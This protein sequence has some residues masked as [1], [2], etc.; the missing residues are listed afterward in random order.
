MSKIIM[1]TDLSLCYSSSDVKYVW[2][3]LEQ[4]I[5]IVMNQFIPKITIKQNHYPKWYTPSLKHQTNCLRSLRKKFSK[6]RTEHLKECLQ[7]AGRKNLLRN[8]I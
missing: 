3:Y 1:N 5:L 2:S 7:T 4:T 6:S 8:I